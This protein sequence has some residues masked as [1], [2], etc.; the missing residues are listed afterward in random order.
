MERDAEIKDLLAKAT[1]GDPQAQY[2]LAEV[3]CLG[4]KVEENYDEALKW[5]HLAAENG[6]PQAQY[7]LAN[8]YYDCYGENFDMEKARMWLF[9][10]AE[11]GGFDAQE[12]LAFAYLDQEFG[13][14]Y[15]LDE[16]I[17]WAELARE[18]TQDEDYDADIIRELFD[19]IKTCQEE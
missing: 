16:A 17:K 7:W 11:N 13:L 8:E 12:R 14:P 5:A 15:N 3:Y 18:N 9:K 19:Q 10:G 2:R 6:Q 1:A 4:Y